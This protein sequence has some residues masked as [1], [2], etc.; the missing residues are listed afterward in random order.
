MDR[1]LGFTTRSV[2]C[3]PLL[4]SNNRV[5]GAIELINK[6]LPS[7]LKSDSES[8]VT[9]TASTEGIF[10]ERDMKI[11]SV[12]GE[13]TGIAVEKAFLYRKVRELAVVD[14]L[15][16]INNR[17]YFNEM[18]QQET[19][20]IKR[21]DQTICILLMDVDGLKNINDTFGH[22]AGD[23]VLCAIA[24]I[25]KS[26]VRE[27]DVVA[28]FGGDEFVVLMPFADES[29][30]AIL[31]ERIQKSI[32]QL[33]KK[34]LISGL[35]LGLSIGIHATGPENVEDLLLKADQKLYQDKTFRKKPEELTSE[36]EIWRY[37]WDN[38]TSE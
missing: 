16:G 36:G 37:L 4:D 38:F 21:Y 1:L 35:K 6:I 34:P 14:S 30:G 25:I 23:R 13:F 8:S 33:N 29:N 17:Q 15:T 12:I 7:A 5:I 19:E 24:D 10:T 20:R 27:S 28:R 11:L 32:E 26:S 31:A 3:V 9:G 22:L 18:F 2:I